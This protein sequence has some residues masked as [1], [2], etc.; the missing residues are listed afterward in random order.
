MAPPSLSLQ[1]TLP[2]N[3]TQFLDPAGLRGA[4]VGVLRQVSELPGTHPAIAALFEAALLAL[5]RGGATLVERFAV[6]GNRLGLDWDAGRGGE[7]PAI[8]AL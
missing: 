4:R 6:R 3:Y 5:Q 2:A 7:G 1:A 8:G